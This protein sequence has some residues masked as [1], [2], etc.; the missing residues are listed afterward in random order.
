MQT[1]AFSRGFFAMWKELWT[2]VS[3]FVK[4]QL[5]NSLRI[6]IATGQDARRQG[7]KETRRSTTGFCTLLGPN[8]ISWSA[9]RKPTVSRLSTEAEYRALGATAQ[10]VTW[11]SFL[12]RDIGLQQSESILLLC[13]NLYV[14]YLS[15]NPA[16]HKRSKYFDTDYHYIREQ[17]ALGLIET[18][19]IPATLQ[20][21]DIFTKSLPRKAFEDLRFKLGVG[22]ASTTSLRG[23]IGDTAQIASET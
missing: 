4:T 5:S 14:V 15:T 2:W 20:I 21:A 7:D 1:L 16:M 13:D 11:I 10:E 9:K 18:R 22:V 19:H 8:L 3:I 23:N 6:V 12:L 17:V